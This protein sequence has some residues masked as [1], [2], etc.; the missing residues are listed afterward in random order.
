MMLPEKAWRVKK[1]EGEGVATGKIEE[2]EDDVVPSRADHDH[3]VQSFLMSSDDEDG[4]E[5]DPEKLGAS[6]DDSSARL[7]ESSRGRRRG[8]GEGQGRADNG[9]DGRCSRGV[10]PSTAHRPAT[11]FSLGGH[12]DGGVHVHATAASSSAQQQQPQQQPLRNEIAGATATAFAA[13]TTE[14][15]K[16]HSPTTAGA[17]EYEGE[18]S[19]GTDG[20]NNATFGGG[21]SDAPNPVS[22][23]NH[24]YHG[25]SP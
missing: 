12:R 19:N 7:Q 17:F 6:D 22:P 15:S 1:E 24:P 4:R 11:V 3:F 8:I 20:P 25:H 16:R 18:N 9:S 2:D 23:T 21:D 13:A 10:R 14:G 5:C